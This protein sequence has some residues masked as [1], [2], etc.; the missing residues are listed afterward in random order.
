MKASESFFSS[1]YVAKV[2][3]MN[4]SKT[5]QQDMFYSGD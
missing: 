5:E 2:D 3:E 4:W 1:I